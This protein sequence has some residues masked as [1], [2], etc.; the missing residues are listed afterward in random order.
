MGLD[1]RSPLVKKLLEAGAMVSGFAFAAMVLF[2]FSGCEKKTKAPLPTAAAKKAVTS[3][4]LRFERPVEIDEPPFLY[5]SEGKRD[6]FRSLIVV[7]GKAEKKVDMAALSP[8]QVY[9][10]VDLKL[11]GL[12]DQGSKGIVA[13]L[14]RPDGKGFTVREGTPVGVRGGKI[15]KIDMNAIYIEETVPDYRGNPTVQHITLELRKEAQ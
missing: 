15:V 12:V 14:V 7:T 13:M 1:T 10:A 9:D 6:P 3:A 4:P 5:T 2:M 11:I 8:L